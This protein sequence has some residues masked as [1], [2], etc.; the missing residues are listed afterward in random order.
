M[1]GDARPVERKIRLWI[2]QQERNRRKEGQLGRIDARGAAPLERRR[3]VVDFSTR[4][5]V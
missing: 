2:A 3:R 1:N 5:P 4:G